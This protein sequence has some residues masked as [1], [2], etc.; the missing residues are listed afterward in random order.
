MKKFRENK[1][2]WIAIAGGLAG[3]L[4]LLGVL[5]CSMDEVVRDETIETAESQAEVTPSPLVAEES[6]HDDASPKV[7]QTPAPLAADTLEKVDFDN[8]VDGLSGAPL[9]PGAV[10]FFSEIGLT[11]PAE[12]LP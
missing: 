4:L 9:H 7:K 5:A 12:L 1:L 8:P 3:A 11:I 10:K 6:A 2:L